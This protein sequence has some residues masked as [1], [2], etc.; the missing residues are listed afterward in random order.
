MQERMLLLQQAGQ[1]WAKS[2]IGARLEM[3]KK[4]LILRRWCCGHKIQYPLEV[5]AISNKLHTATPT[6]YYPTET[7]A[8]AIGQHDEEYG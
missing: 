6:E 2:K 7:S 1:D 4:N 3:N 5:F 8:L